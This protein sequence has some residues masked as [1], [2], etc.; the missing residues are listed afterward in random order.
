MYTF[1]CAYMYTYIKNI[2]MTIHICVYIHTYMYIFVYI[3]KYVQVAPSTKG[4]N[5]DHM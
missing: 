1:T 2:C 3:F 5:A 4:M